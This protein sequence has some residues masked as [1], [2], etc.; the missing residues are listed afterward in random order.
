MTN[1]ERQKRYR[2]RKRQEASD[3]FV[4]IPPKTVPK[5]APNVMEN[6]SE[7]QEIRQNT[8]SAPVKSIPSHEPVTRIASIEDYHAHPDDYAFRACAEL[9]NWGAWMSPD[10]LK[11]SEFSANRVSM[12]GDWDYKDE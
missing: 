12:P 1:A 6:P 2:D 3:K 9:L 4:T 10:E 7:A 8:I 5:P 11:F